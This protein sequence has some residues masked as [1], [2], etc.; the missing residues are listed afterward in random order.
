MRGQKPRRRCSLEDEK[1][2][3]TIGAADSSDALLALYQNA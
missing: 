1:T 3:K 2:R